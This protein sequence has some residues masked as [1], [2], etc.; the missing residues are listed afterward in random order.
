MVSCSNEKNLYEFYRLIGEGRFAS[1]IVGPNFNAVSGK[2]GSWPQLI[3]DIHF[4]RSSGLEFS[5]IF[6]DVAENLDVRFA[7]CNRAL[8]T[9]SDQELLRLNEIFPVG[10]WQLM[11][12]S[13]KDDLNIKLQEKYELRS[14]INPA[15][16]D[17]YVSLV[18]NNLMNGQEV[19]CD[20]FQELIHNA[21]VEIYGLFI[22]DELVSGLLSYAGANKVA[23]LYF[24][25]TKQD[26]RKKGLA[27]GIIGNVL[28]LLFQQ[29]IEKV[30]LQALPKALTLYARLG[31]AHQ[32]ELVIF[33]KK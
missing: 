11:E 25:S 26:Y 17:E 19:K 5:K 30:V 14:L 13:S 31:F 22:G 10:N 24:I 27:A 33:W 2:E 16:V 20:L 1:F 32:G 21:G 29:G 6:S 9:T 3:F 28:K 12:I 8:F 15:E 4:N 23:G 18:N 7:V